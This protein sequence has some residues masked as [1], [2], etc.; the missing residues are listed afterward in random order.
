MYLLRIGLLLLLLA[1]QSAFAKQPPTDNPYENRYGTP[2]HWTRSIHWDRITNVPSVTGLLTAGNRID[3][4][5]LQQTIQKISAGGGGVLYFPAGTYQFAAHVLLADGVVLRGE[6]PSTVKQAQ[7]NTYAPPT[8]FEFPR[9]VPSREGA[10]TANG[11]A[12]KCIMAAAGPTQNFGLVDLDI[13]RA[14]IAFDPAMLPGGPSDKTLYR[15]VIVMGIRQN[16]CALP[17]ANIPTGTQQGEKRAWQRWP[18]TDIGNINIAVSQN[19]TLANNRLNDAITDEFEQPNYLTDDGFLFAGSQAL[20]SYS[21]Q[22]GIRVNAGA[23]VDPTANL[24]IVD[25]YVR[26]NQPERGIRAVAG[27]RQQANVIEPRGTASP[28][29]LDGHRYSQ[30]HWNT[31]ADKSGL[32]TKGIY[33]YSD[34]DSLPFRF[35]H[36]P[37]TKPG[38]KYPIVLFFHGQGEAGRD[39]RKQLEQFVTQ[40]MTDEARSK[41]PCFLMAPQHPDSASFTTWSMHSVPSWRVQASMKLIDSLARTVPIDLDRI[42]VMGL[43]T[44]ANTTI[45]ALIRYP[46]QFAAA[47]I[48]SPYWTLNKEHAALMRKTAIWV[49]WGAQDRYIPPIYTRL[50][51]SKLRG[52]GATPLTTEFPNVG[53]NCWA[54]L[55]QDPQFM[56]WLFQQQKKR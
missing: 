47:V 20:F 55:S 49:A 7:N 17:A 36:P 52:A 37:K 44:G 56:P 13:N 46:N 31:L 8:R 35:M 14:V 22:Y 40:F 5:V 53:I 41:F 21:S 38:Q 11:S 4:L 27:I 23:T 25:N 30:N 26:V 18:R 39:N 33:H 19:L 34:V 3:S 15:N 1:A 32:L 45:D 10:G 29:I 51:V 43:T 9:Y 24:E 28:P 16:N 50:F 2:E 12:F 6:Q 48:M 42:Y 54:P